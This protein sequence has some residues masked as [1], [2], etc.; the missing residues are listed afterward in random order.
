MG[1]RVDVKDLIDATVVAEL[2]GLRHRNSVRVYRT[3]YPN[4][5]EPVVDM[6]S[7]RCL[8]WVRQDIEAWLAQRS[9]PR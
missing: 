3:R 5:P 8:L 9:K 2:I 4:F 7:G 6:G 1:R